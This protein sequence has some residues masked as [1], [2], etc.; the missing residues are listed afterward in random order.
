MMSIQEIQRKME[1]DAI[2]VFRNNQFL[3]Q[4][5]LAEENQ[6]LNLCG[7][8]GSAGTMV[9]MRKKAFLFVDGRYEIQAKKEVDL[10]KVEVIVESADYNILTWLKDNLAESSITYNPWQVSE[11]RLQRLKRLLPKATFVSAPHIIPTKRAKVFEHEL[12]YAGW[13]A[14]EKIKL[15]CKDV[16]LKDN[17][18]CLISAADSVSWLLNLRS[19]ALPDTPII[20]AMALIDAKKEVIIFGDNLILPKEL[21]FKKYPL[22]K[23]ESL[24]KSLHPKR[25]IMDFGVTP[26]AIKELCQ[27]LEIKTVDKVDWCFLSKAQKNKAELQGMINSHIRDGVAMCKFLSW[28]EKNYEGKTEIEVA[29]KLL[30]FRKRQPLFYSLSF[31]TIVGSGENAAIIHYQPK[32]KTCAEIK[33]NSVLLID[34]GGQY[35]DGTT[36]ITRTLAVG[37]PSKDMVEKFT[38]VLKAHIALSAQKFPEHT[39]GS[40][41]DAICRS[42]LWRNALD[43]K[44]GTGHGVGCFLNVHEGPQSISVSGNKYP[45]EPYMVLSI[46]PGYYREGDFGIRIEN[47][48]YVKKAKEKGFLNFVPLTFVPIDKRLI[49]KYLLSQEEILWLNNYHKKVYKL[50]APNLNETERKWLKGACSSL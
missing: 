49:N 48:V 43:Y 15:L 24:L 21:S 28:F 46:E 39:S 8:S 12:E 33:K 11:S 14:K 18:L 34:S 26:A 4:D 36:D 27:K 7:F 10:K 30:D 45:L 17:E 40:R 38:L 19:N 44:H 16:G 1:T 3:G 9:I 31:E 25:M 41:L 47:L 13:A 29:K 42:I 20:R 5:V 37:K 6:I 50:I 23:I 32:E 2:I 22:N 35:F